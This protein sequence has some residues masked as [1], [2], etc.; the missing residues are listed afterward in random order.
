MM[1]NV[2]LSLPDIRVWET[3]YWS[4]IPAVVPSVLNEFVI[5]LCFLKL[6]L[7]PISV[8]HNSS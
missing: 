1:S 2:W 3:A 6:P 4:E 8:S 7:K 5:V